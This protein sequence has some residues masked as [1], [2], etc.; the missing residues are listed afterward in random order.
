MNRFAFRIF[1]ID[2]AWYGIIM[3]FAIAFATYLTMRIATKRGYSKD[4]ILDLALWVIPFAI[5]GARL[6]YV[7][8][9]WEHYASNP[10]SV[11]YIRQGGMAIHG[12]IFGGLLGGFIHCKRKGLNFADL[13]DMVCMPLILAQSIGRWGN[14]TNGEAHGGPTS[15]PWAIEVGGEMVHP[16]FL[17]ESLWNLLCF[18][19]LVLA[20]QKRKYY[21]THFMYYLMMYSVGRFFIEGLRTDS[22]MF[23]GLRAAQMVSVALIL[24]AIV[25][26]Y[27]IRKNPENRIVDRSIK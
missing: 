20:F 26:I 12:G 7:A 9:Q 17:Y 1:G 8:F 23:F 13:A 27:I 21:G 18:I 10:I 5:V 2:I 19:V 22:L 11:L 16:T 24:L 6:Y 25:S 14:F 15:L 3:T 4:D